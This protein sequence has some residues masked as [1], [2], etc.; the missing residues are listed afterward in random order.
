M[1][2]EL[3]TMAVA[4]EGS[5]DYRVLRRLVPH[6]PAE[7]ATD[8][9]AT[10]EPTAT[11]VFLDV[12]ST[13]LDPRRDE[14]I[15]LAMVTF[16]FTAA[17]R[18]V[19]VGDTFDRLRQ[20]SSLIPPII[21]RLTGITDA[22]VAGQA[23][24][25]D[26]VAAFVAPADLIIAH[27]ARFDRR[28]AERLHP[29]FVGKRWACSMTQALWQEHGFEGVKLAYLLMSAGL[30]H[31][32]HRALDDCHAAL[33]L[34]GRPLGNTGRSALAQRPRRSR[35]HHMA[36]ARGRSTL[37]AQG[38]AALARL[39][40]EQRRGR[41][42]ARLVHRPRRGGGRRR[43][44]HAACRGVR[45]GLG[46]GDHADHRAQPLLRPGLTSDAGSC[47]DRWMRRP[48]RRCRRRE[49]LRNV[50]AEYEE[51]ALAALRA[52]AEQHS[53]LLYDREALRR[54]ICALDGRDGSD[55]CDGFVGP[56]DE[57]PRDPDH[58]PSAE[59]RHRLTQLRRIERDRLGP[60]R[61]LLVGSPAMLAR[62]EVL[63]AEAPHFAPFVGLVARAVALSAASDT[64]LRLAPVLL[65]GAPGIGKTWVLKRLAAALGSTA[66]FL[67][68]NMLDT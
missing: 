33:A 42:A 44:R 23:I 52:A 36:A 65:V 51:A 4:L 18:I 27:N 13:G 48:A 41:A 15:E 39:P 46:A 58:D 29:V 64:P 49:G 14:V 28:F 12:E 63:A 43:G 61:R 67:P 34:L 25:A 53:V 59:E 10:A 57:A 66:E 6:A 54:A 11:G 62:V 32:S 47:D 19:E 45:P 55:E 35:P 7:N 26:E 40:L 20:P 2:D 56:E 8:A 24:D 50:A 37:R 5:G 21:T 16:R 68:V 9:E 17:G 22:M 60:R 3:E 38:P 30:F 31:G 1:D